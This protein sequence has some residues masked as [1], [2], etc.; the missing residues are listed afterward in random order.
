MAK[1]IECLILSLLHAT[2][3]IQTICALDCHLLPTVQ[4]FDIRQLRKLDSNLFKKRIFIVNK[5][6]LVTLC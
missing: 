1:F 3:Q 6:P 5:L 2:I 4:R